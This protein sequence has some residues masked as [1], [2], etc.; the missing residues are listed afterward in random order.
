MARTVFQTKLAHTVLLCL[1]SVQFYT[2]FTVLNIFLYS[3][4]IEFVHDNNLPIQL[5]CDLELQMQQ[6]AFGGRERKA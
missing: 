2:K 5:A 4:E 1:F 3:C 6:F